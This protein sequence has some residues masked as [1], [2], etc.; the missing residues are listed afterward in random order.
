MTK[1][2]FNESDIYEAYRKLKTYFYYDNTNHHMRRKIA[3][4]EAD[5]IATKLINLKND[6]NK[7]ESTKYFNIKQYGKIS[8]YTQP[9][10]FKNNIVDKEGLIVTNR[11]VSEQYELDG[12]NFFIDLPI[13]LHIINVLW[14]MKLGYLLDSQYCNYSDREKSYCFANKLQIDAET[15]K[16]KSGNKLFKTYAYQYQ[17]WRDECI[18]VAEDLLQNHKKDIVFRTLLKSVFVILNRCVWLCA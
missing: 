11:Y 8:F 2:L 14:I 9:K 13:E 5:S 4:Y 1:E 3:Q 17:Q 18:G 15:G 12:F 16:I 10:S 7:Y 6:L